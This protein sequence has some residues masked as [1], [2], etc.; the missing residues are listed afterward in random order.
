M[1]E[2]EKMSTNE[3]EM[4]AVRRKKRR[5]ALTAGKKA[6]II[7]ILAL[8]IIVLAATSLFVFY[9]PNTER[10]T[11]T[12]VVT[13]TDEHGSVVTDNEGNA[14]TEIIS[15][16]PSEKVDS[17]NILVLGHDRAAMLTDVFMLV[18]IDNR[19]NSITVMQI[20][21]DTWVSDH[22]GPE[23]T[24]HYVISNKINAVFSTYFNYHRYNE[25][26]DTSEAYDKAL[27]SV[28]DV[29]EE[30]LFINIDYSVIM[31]LDGFQKIVDI[32]GGVEMYVER[33]M[34]YQDPEQGLYI[35]IPAGYQTLNGHQAE[36]FVRYRKG[37]ATADLGRQNAQKQFMTSLFSKAKS[38][39]SLSNADK[40]KDIADAIYTYIDTDMSAA[41]ILFFA[42]SLLKCD[43]SEMNM[44]TMPGNLVGQYYVMNREA[45]Y[46]VMNTSYNL[47]TT[48]IPDAAFD[49]G[50]LFNNTGDYY[51]SYAYKLPANEVFDNTVF[52]GADVD[53]DGVDLPW[54]NY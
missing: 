28:A 5:G 22:K 20:P 32:L 17:Y 33:P 3:K 46:G 53:K 6:A 50:S 34:V 51:I 27:T 9:R 1:P 52:N 4:A 43:L 29:L 38:T 39:L 31:D 18:N 42:K 26:M 19:D 37:Y 40:L 30:N 23:G 15:V 21:R 7:V 24:Y 41:E 35:N 12:A 8:Y 25:G 48:D 13:Q 14:V 2:N 54:N 36:G 45:V 44:M 49:S 11:L 10:N 16:D 47:N